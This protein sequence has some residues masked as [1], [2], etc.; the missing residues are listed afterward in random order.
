MS[1]FH[2]HVDAFEISPEF[3]HFLTDQLGFYRSDFAGHPEG[4][5]GFEPPHH[6]TLKLKDV[7]EFRS[8]FDEVVRTA[9]AGTHMMGY[10]EGEVI[11]EDIEIEEK[12]FRESVPA[13]FRIAT[14]SLPAGH[15]RESE[16]HVTLDRDRSDSRLIEALARMGFFAAYLPKPYGTAQIFTVQGSRVLVGE[17]MPDLLTFLR[18]A[19]G[20]VSCS[21][22]EE[23]IAA[24]WMSDPPVR[25]PPVISTVERPSKH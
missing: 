6:L 11:A 24:W 19:G 21:V 9:R 17:L 1:N 16:I 14:T 8:Q 10:V 13:P 20:A 25:L 23:R 4:V 7:N 2:I 3:E 18:S 15:F 22:K 5:E 12:P